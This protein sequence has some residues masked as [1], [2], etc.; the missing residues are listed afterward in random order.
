[1]K[2]NRSGTRDQGRGDLS[3]GAEVPLSVHDLTVAYERK[4]VIWDI[5]LDFPANAIVRHNR[6]EWR[7]GQE[8]ADQGVSR[9]GAAGERRD[10]RVWPTLRAANGSGWAMCRSGE[11]VDWD[12]PVSV[13][14]VVTMGTYGRLGWLRPGEPAQ[15]RAR[16]R[17]AGAGGDGGFLP[18]ARS[19]SFQA[20][21]NSG[22][23]SRGPWR[24]TRTSI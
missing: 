3:H 22:L 8:H 14:D 17:G 1:M 10:P 21:N 9:F 24:R 15:P 5:D 2:K 6:A 19:A 7:G 16:P 12:F 18:R 11:S 23:F 20:G 4:P 13:L